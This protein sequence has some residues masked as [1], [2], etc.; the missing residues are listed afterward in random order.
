V[1]DDTGRLSRPVR[2]AA[3]GLLSPERSRDE[4]AADELADTSHVDLAHVLT[5]VEDSLLRPNDGARL[6]RAIVQ[7][8][9]ERFAPVLRQPA[10]RG[11]YLA[12]EDYL[13][14]QLGVDIAGRLHTGRSRNDLKATV[15]RLAARR[16]LADLA[17]AVLYLV[18]VL[19][20]RS[21]RY[22]AVVM[23]LYT[24]QQPAVPTT[25]GHYYAAVATAIV[26]EVDAAGAAVLADLDTCPL[27]AA[28]G[29]GTSV[30]VRHDRTAELLGFARVSANSIDAV[31]SRDYALAA[32]AHLAILGVTLSRLTHDLQLWTGQEYG[33]LELPDDLTGS[34]S[35]MPQ[36]RNAFLL[37]H[38]QGM[39]GRVV[40]TLMA[41]LTAAHATPYT[42]SIAVGTEAVGE[43]DRAS[44]IARSAAHLLAMHV[45]AARPDSDRML[46]RAADSHT[47]A[48]A[49]AERMVADG[50]PFR[51]AHRRVGELVV[52]ALRTGESLQSVAK[53]SDDAAAA[54]ADGLDV[55]SAVMATSHGAGPQAAR[56]SALRAA[57]RAAFAPLGDTQ[58]RWL[59]ARA[60]LDRAVDELFASAPE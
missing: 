37:E 20:R 57:Q 27:G 42:N 26:R 1:A 51:A 24:H 30:A 40:G 9:R 4:L 13:I 59:R 50:M 31:A 8:Q 3:N 5:L 53:R 49:L 54:A 23:P 7:L 19:V 52:E 39:T 32:I 43:L 11:L 48:M 55:L 29:G 16:T 2:A 15:Q 47:V 56:R 41:A 22:E 45:A 10:P 60:D 44:G 35:A 38:V 58:Q 25:L 36:K 46:R 34:S 14:E 28:A 33:F 12:Y 6:A 21:E 17:R 18:A